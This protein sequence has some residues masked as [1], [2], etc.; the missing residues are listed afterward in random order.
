MRK[1]ANSSNST[2]STN[3]TIFFFACVVFMFG[4]LLY[5]SH[6][7]LGIE[8]DH[9]SNTRIYVTNSYKKAYP[10][11]DAIKVLKEAEEAANFEINLIVNKSKELISIGNNYIIHNSKLTNNTTTTTTTASATTVSALDVTQFHHNLQCPKASGSAEMLQFW[12]QPT[13]SDLMYESPFAKV[14]PAIK[15]V[16]FEPDVGGWNNIRMQMETVLVFAASTGRIL[17][18]PPDQPMYLLNKGKG[19]QKAHSFADFFPFEVISKR[20]KVISME[21][22]MQREAI[23]GHLRNNSNGKVAYPPNN[24]T[25]FECTDRDDRLSMWSYLHDVSSVPLWKCMK[26]FLVIPSAPGVNVTNG[27]NAEE[28]IKRREIFASGREFH[29]YDDYW[30]NQRVIHFISKPELGLRLLEHFYTFL[31]FEDPA[32]D[33]YYKRFVRDCVHYIDI[34]F[35]K[36]AIIIEKL[37]QEAIDGKFSTFHIRRGEF[38]YKEVKIPAA[39]MMENVGSF[40]PEKQLLYIAT[41]EKDKTFFKAFKERFPTIRYL[42]DYMDLA[43]LYDINPNYL[44]MIDQV[45]CSKGEYFVGTWFSTFS[46]YITRMRGYLGYHDHSV[47]YGDKKH[48]DRFQHDEL[49]MFPYYMREWNVSWT[50][51]DY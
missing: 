50:H 31:H 26:E 35:C 5:S 46:G 7:Q 43:N 25:V 45:V 9:K 24:K 36:A 4:F 11:E 18:L 6:L 38:Q 2:L 10:V 22:F 19:H 21:E 29:V 30:Q 42:D 34:I 48:R 13:L 17:V 51:I 23:T 15:Y 32:M 1:K 3:C 49:P 37:Q 14:G 40:I 20:V 47:W 28:S 39:K 8:E 16:T 44:G 12:K 41:D 33:R 27:P